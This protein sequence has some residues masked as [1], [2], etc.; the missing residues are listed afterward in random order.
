MIIIAIIRVSGYVQNNTFDIV[1]LFF[2]HQLE[3]AVA[4]IMVSLTTF[5]SLL[6]IKARKAREK[7]VLKRFW[8]SNRPQLPARYFKKTTQDDSKSQQLLSVPRATLTG[9]R[10]F[11]NGNG[12]CDEAM[13]ISHTSEKNWPRAV[14][15]D[16][17]NIE[18]DQL[19]TE[20]EIWDEPRLQ[21]QQVLFG[22][23]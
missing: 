15:H 17:Q 8:F 6:A 11:I 16:P 3:G 21:G 13:G 19:S 20:L 1:W 10:T 9:M 12:I 18:I 2:W 4:I 14:S 23:R 22:N 7:K 5:R